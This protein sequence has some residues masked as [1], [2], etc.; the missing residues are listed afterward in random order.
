MSITRIS[1]INYLFFNIIKYPNISIT[2]ILKLSL[3]KYRLNI[4]Q[5]LGI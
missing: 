2:Q 4:F 3:D 1:D 5:I